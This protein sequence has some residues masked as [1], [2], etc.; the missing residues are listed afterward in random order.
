MIKY[1]FYLLVS[2]VSYVSEYEVSE[3]I[4][5]LQIQNNSIFPTPTIN[6][7]RTLDYGGLDLNLINMD[8]V[9]FVDNLI[10]QTIEDT[11]EK[12][13]SIVDNDW[14]SGPWYKHE[15]LNMW[16][17]YYDRS[18]I[19]DIDNASIAVTIY[20]D[21]DIFY[22][23]KVSY[24]MCNLSDLFLKEEFSMEDF[25]SFAKIYYSV[26]ANAFGVYFYY[27]NFIF[28]FL[29]NMDNSITKDTKVTIRK[30]ENE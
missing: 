17:G 19:I 26:E 4:N 3:S 15:N 2:L 10:G 18:D 27:D 25:D 23:E 30:V 28:S 9:N 16:V 21:Y 24:V 5:R 14:I 11:T 6:N 8:F 12:Y 22:N 13:G 29:I 20:E 7:E 1:I